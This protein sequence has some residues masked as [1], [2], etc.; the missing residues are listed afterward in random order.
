MQME[1]WRHMFVLGLPWAEKVL[2]PIF[3][4]AFLIVGL[5]LAGKRELAQLNPFDLVVLLIIS[6]VL[7]NAAI[8]SDNSLGGGLLG[9]AVIIA[10]NK[11]DLLVLMGLE[12]EHGSPPRGSRLSAG[13]PAGSI[14]RRAGAGEAT[15]DRSGWFVAAST[16]RTRSLPIV[17]L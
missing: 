9:A 13:L 6:N 16:T 10:L 11:A 14:Q 17:R 12:I 1:I 7:Q 15:R 2:R 4:Y 3:V 5:R 8:G